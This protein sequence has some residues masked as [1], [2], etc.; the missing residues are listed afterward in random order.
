MPS[1]LKMYVH[2][3]T[4]TRMFTVALFIRSKKWKQLKHRSMTAGKQNVLYPYNGMLFTGNTK[5]RSTDTPPCT[6]NLEN[7]MPSES[8]QTLLF[9]RSVVSNSLQPHDCSKPGHMLDDSW[10]VTCPEQAQST[11]TESSGCLGPGEN[12]G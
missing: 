2:T 4:C 10:Y 7:L 12:G 3:Q 5:G 8:S 6:T 11:E 1:K 9:S